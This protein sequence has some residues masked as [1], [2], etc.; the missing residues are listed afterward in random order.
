MTYRKEP[1]M[2]GYMLA[3]LTKGEAEHIYGLPQVRHVADLADGNTFVAFNGELP[4][5]I[6]T[7]GLILSVEQGAQD[8]LFPLIPKIRSKIEDGSTEYL[9]LYTV[10][11][12]RNVPWPTDVQVSAVGLDLVLVLSTLP[13]RGEPLWASESLRIWDKRLESV[14]A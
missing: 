11:G 4:Y 13:L 2:D 10:A 1:P 6:P 14:D 3:R 9:G 12:L 5:T 8:F 7:G